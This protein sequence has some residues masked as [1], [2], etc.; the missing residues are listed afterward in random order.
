[1]RAALRYRARVGKDLDVVLFGAT[2]FVGRLTAAY[3]AE[4]APENA[5]I[6]LAGRNRHR[7]EALRRQL[8]HRAADWEILVADT[9]EPETL[10]AI[11]ERTAVVA[12]TAGPYARVGLPLV[13]A[14]ALAG[15][16][17][18]DLTGEVLFVRESAAAWHQRAVD[19]GARIVHAC[20]F[21][22]IPSDL[23][24]LVTADAAADDGEGE[25]TTTVLSVR[26]MRGGVSG[27]TID[28][29]RYQAILARADSSVRAILADPFA[30]S[31]DPAREP[32][33]PADEKEPREPEGPVQ[34]VLTTVG[35]FAR[36]LPVRWDPQTGRWTGPFVMA[37]FNTRI[38]R[39]S[40]A[41]LGWRYGR[42]FRYREVVD[43][44]TGP[45]ASVMAGG[46][47]A[48]ML[49]L[50]AA[51]SFEPTRSVLDRV[52]PRPGEGPDEQRRAGGRFRMIITTTT[53]TGATY[54]TT[55]GADKD[56]GY[57]GTAVMLGE[58]ALALAFDEQRLP[59]AA[60]VLTPATGL[61]H[62]LV[63]RL[64]DQDFTFDCKRTL[65]E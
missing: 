50:F 58:S 26:S 33:R 48:A 61:G 40:N 64:R 16:H 17:Y 60:G 24:V 62:V 56:P 31:P 10:T 13:E 28:S 51:M 65:S 25:L 27:G 47:T 63:E 21:D 34:S 29:M 20:G 9:S 32:T 8:P 44:G 37:G 42:T 15:T 2:G 23:G 36:K 46:M 30:L 41:L 11:V 6:A 45:Q 5:R 43:F 49:A 57:D 35:G 18:C 12:T 1:M 7:L 59:G 39:R 19:T 3:L 14:C 54:R 55:V 38:V 53:T 4:H 52:L 22:S